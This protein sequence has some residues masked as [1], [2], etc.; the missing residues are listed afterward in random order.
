MRVDL[1]PAGKLKYKVPAAPGLTLEFVVGEDGRATAIATPQ[2]TLSR[3][4]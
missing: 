1:E 2:G 4:D 3:A